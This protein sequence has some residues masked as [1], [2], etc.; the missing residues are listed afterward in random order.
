MKTISITKA[1]QDLYNLVDEA[2]INS[3]PIQITSK[4]GNA[5]LISSDDWN[6][7]QETLY[8]ISVPE[9]KNSII[10]GLNTP[11]D[12]CLEDIEWDIN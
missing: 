4:R 7:I 6:A 1:R 9:L 11:L 12:E 3:E 10:E 2:L 8:L 5:I